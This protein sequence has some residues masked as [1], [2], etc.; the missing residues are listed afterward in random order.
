MTEKEAEI[1][2]NYLKSN[3]MVLCFYNNLL[4]SKEA[5]EKVINS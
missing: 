4:I 5:C 1:I 3:N 2:L